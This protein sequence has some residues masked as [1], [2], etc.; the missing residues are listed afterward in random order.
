MTAEIVQE[1]LWTESAKITFQNII[2]WLRQESSEKEV[3]KFINRTEEVLALSK[4]YPEM[5]CLSIKRK[6]V[7]ISIL[8]KLQNWYTTIIS[9]K[10]KL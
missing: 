6:N 4:H 9:G 3:D 7:R 10:D 1:I 5:C 8:D 2:A